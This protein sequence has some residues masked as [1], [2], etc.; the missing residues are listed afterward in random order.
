M[1]HST[2]HNLSQLNMTSSLKISQRL[3][4]CCFTPWITRR[5]ASRLP[6]HNSACFV[7]WKRVS[8]HFLT[9]A[10]YNAYQF[11]AK[12]HPNAD[13]CMRKTLI[14]SLSPISK[15]CSTSAFSSMFCHKRRRRLFPTFT[16][17]SIELHIKIAFSILAKHPAETQHFGFRFASLC[18][19]TPSNAFYCTIISNKILIARHLWQPS[20][21]AEYSAHGICLHD[22]YNSSK[23]AVQVALAA[24]PRRRLIKKLLSHVIAWVF[25]SKLYNMI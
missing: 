5:T 19:A 1:A 10:V 6:M 11:A 7:F 16:N 13:V 20:N 21:A 4:T 15:P 24:S 3:L 12:Q 23:S 8:Q 18:K 17:L 14:C 22:T 25:N 2:A 9:I